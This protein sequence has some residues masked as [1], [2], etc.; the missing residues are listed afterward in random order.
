MPGRLSS[1]DT[2]TTGARRRP[3]FHREVGEKERLRGRRSKSESKSKS[4]S[5]SEVLKSGRVEKDDDHTLE[6]GC[7][8]YVSVFVDRTPRRGAHDDAELT[9][10]PPLN[11]TTH[12]LHLL[13]VRPAVPPSV[14]PTT[15]LQHPLFVLSPPPRSRSLPPHLSS[16]VEIK[17]TQTSRHATPSQHERYSDDTPD[18]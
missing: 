10:K 1:I 14:A 16:Q 12:T 13:L 4:K 15:P 5:E 3:L 8:W 9:N 7:V 18:E 6:T 17:S 2:L 11:L